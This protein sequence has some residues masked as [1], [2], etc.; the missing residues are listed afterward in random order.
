MEKEV[1]LN[2]ADIF[3]IS[4]TNGPGRRSVI[5]VQGCTLKCPGCFNPEFQPHKAHYLVDVEKIAKKIVEVCYKNQCEGISITGGEPF[6]QS[7]ALSQFTDIIR[8]SGLTIVCFT[9]YQYETLVKSKNK[10][11]EKLLSN[12]DILIAG[13]FK[14]NNFYK[15]TWFDDP[16]KEIVFL[17]K[18]YSENILYPAKSVEMIVKGNKIAITG[19][20]DI[21]DYQILEEILNEEQININE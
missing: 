14:E 1:F 10:N 16:D 6:Q 20:T 15:R 7:N 21:S 5:W 9:G 4:Y 17:S 12:I 13:P 18:K 8:K 19:F 2:V 11:I 3:P